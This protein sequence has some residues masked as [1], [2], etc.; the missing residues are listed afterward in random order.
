M[1]LTLLI[2]TLLIGMALLILEIVALPGGVAGIF[3]GLL[4]AFGV[5]QSYM[6]LGLNWGTV[7]LGCVVLFGVAMLIILMKGKTWKK[8]SLNEES[9]STV[10]QEPAVIA[11]GATG[12]TIARLAPTGKALIEGQLVEV[13][14]INKFIDP[15]RPIEVVAVEG[16]RIDVVET[17]D[18]RFEAVEANQAINN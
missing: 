13:H 11:V 9:D 7:V 18:D 10:N 4:L 2:I 8:F 3:G 5:W 14:A 17:E 15:D 12:K 1:N 16:Y 6:L